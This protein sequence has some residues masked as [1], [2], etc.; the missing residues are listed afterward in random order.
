MSNRCLFWL[1]TLSFFFMSLSSF[2]TEPLIA[3]GNFVT[4]DNQ[5]PLLALHFSQD[6]HWEYPASVYESP[7]PENY[8]SGSRFSASTC[9]APRCFGVGFYYDTNYY[10]R[11]LIALSN[12]A[13]L[14]WK[15][16]N[17]PNPPEW[18]G[19]INK[20]RF[21]SISCGK[22]S[23]LS[24]GYYQN[25]QGLEYPLLAIG[26]DEWNYAN[27]QIQQALPDDFYK[28]E[29][30]DIFCNDKICTVAGHYR[31]ASD[32]PFPLLLL[33]EDEGKHWSKPISK[34]QLPKDFI[35]GYF[36]KVSCHKTF[37]ATVGVYSN[38]NQRKPLITL[39]NDSGKHWESPTLFLPDDFVSG[40]FSHIDCS[41]NF[42][43]AVGSY[44]NASTTLP[45]LYY[46]ND[47]GRTWI[48]AEY[49]SHSGLPYGLEDAE[50]I[51]AAC[52]NSFCI[53]VGSYHDRVGAH[54]LIAVSTNKG[55]T[56]D[57]PDS[58]TTS[59]PAA[60]VGDGEL[61]HAS[62]REKTCI[63]VGNYLDDEAHFP[64]LAIS[65]NK[66]KT[67]EF[68]SSIAEKNNLPPNYLFG[69]FDSSS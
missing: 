34:A 44:D 24:V 38:E 22:H 39:S 52:G 50:L 67:W 54:P 5:R 42:C 33:T 26:L 9:K 28:G 35:S 63:A 45:L 37:C 69:Q 4:E 68:N 51:H 16:L 14:D 25:Q 59:V 41:N 55:K 60:D 58:A 46:S 29:L 65:Y 3:I 23:C 49:I 11:P 53:A 40:S 36:N 66:G 31:N 57:Y 12:N 48:Y 20:G 47:E 19:Q 6:N 10:N 62:C 30:E 17:P 15:Y 2:A 18:N 27:T 61:V 43:I 64:L 13:G 21:E 32:T 8:D 1:Y 56:W 7:L